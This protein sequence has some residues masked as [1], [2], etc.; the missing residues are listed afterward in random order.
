MNKIKRGMPTP[1]TRKEFEHN[2]YLT[3]ENALRKLNNK[4]HDPFFIRRTLPQLKNIKYLPNGRINFNSI[5][6]SLRLQ[7]NTQYWI[8]I[9]STYYSQ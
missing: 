5:D 1:S 4:Q 3:I 9:N 8:E 7:A 2:I 6:E